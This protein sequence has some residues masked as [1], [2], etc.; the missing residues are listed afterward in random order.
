MLMSEPVVHVVVHN[1]LAESVKMSDCAQRIQRPDAD[2]DVHCFFI[3][4]S[5]PILIARE[6]GLSLTSLII[7]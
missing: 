3:S 4:P 6:G 7:H 2:V 5:P 1:F